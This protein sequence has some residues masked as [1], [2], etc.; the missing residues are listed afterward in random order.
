MNESRLIY[1]IE[2]FANWLILVLFVFPIIPIPLANFFTILMIFFNLLAWI[3]R[4]NKET[5]IS[6]YWLLLYALLPSIYALELFVTPN[7]GVTAELVQ[8]K[9]LLLVLPLGFYWASSSPT[10]HKTT[11]YALWVFAFSVGILVLKS[12]VTIAIWGL[13]NHALNSGGWAFAFRKTMEDISHSHPTYFSLFIGFTVLFL[14]R[15]AVHLTY[16][17]YQ[18]ILIFSS[19]ILLGVLLALASRMVVFATIIGVI[20]IIMLEIKQTSNKIILASMLLLLSLLSWKFLP[21]FQERLVSS[22]IQQDSKDNRPTIYSCD[23]L[24]A[25]ENWLFGIGA[26][27]LQS[28]LNTCYIY[29][30]PTMVLDG[31]TYNTHNEYFNILCAKGIIGLMSFILLLFFL[32]RKSYSQKNLRYLL[33]LCILTFFTENLLDRQHGLFFFALISSYFVFLNQQN[34]QFKATLKS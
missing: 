4:K 33:I 20:W 9:I 30:N 32:I 28:A 22:T 8:R 16:K 1:Y 5:T 29:T 24:I 11:P 23:L 18:L 2:H 14:L 6:K 15:K 13:D 31:K 25:K 34:L 26:G 21:S 10:I 27:N 17:K 19:F 3:L 7:W 12:L